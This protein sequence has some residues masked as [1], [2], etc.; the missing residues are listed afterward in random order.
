MDEKPQYEQEIVPQNESI[1]AV[2][3]Q[4]KYQEYSLYNLTSWL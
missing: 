2:H 3:I 4:S 1:K